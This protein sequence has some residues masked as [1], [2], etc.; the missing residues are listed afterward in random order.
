MSP[1]KDPA[2]KMADGRE[3]REEREKRREQEKPAT[4]Y[5]LRRRLFQRPMIGLP[6]SSLCS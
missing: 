1:E 5:R 6:S 3:E 2:F 4:V